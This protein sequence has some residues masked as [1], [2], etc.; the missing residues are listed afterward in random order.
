MGTIVL[1]TFRTLNMAHTSCMSPFPAV[2]ALQYSRV[3][4]CSMHYG[5]EV[6]YIEMPVDDSLGFGAVLH[7]PNIDPNNGHV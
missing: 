4:V 2:F 1:D 3:H 7:V 6:A 5:N